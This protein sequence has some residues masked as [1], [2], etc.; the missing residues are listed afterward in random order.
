M[1]VQFHLWV[2][3]NKIND[4]ETGLYSVYGLYIVRLQEHKSTH[5]AQAARTS[6]ANPQSTDQPKNRKRT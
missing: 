2:N 6:R 1:Y 3:I 5:H 4:Q